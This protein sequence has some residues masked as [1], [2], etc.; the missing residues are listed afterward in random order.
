MISTGIEI[1]RRR[2]NSHIDS[3]SS[4][5]RQVNIKLHGHPETAYQ[6]FFAHDSITA[7]LE[8]QGFKVKRHAYGLETSFEA[9]IGSGGRLIV[10]CA[11]DDALPNIGHACGH[12]LIATSSIGAFLGAAT[13]LR[14]SGFAGRIRLLGTPAEEGGG[15]KVKLID[16]GAFKDDVAAAIMVHP[17]SQ[18][19]ISSDER[20]SG[21]AGIRSNASYKLRI[22]YKGKPA[23]AAGDPWNG[24]NALDAAVAAYNN[25]ALLRQQIQD[26]ERVHGVI[27]VG[28]TVPNVITEYT[29]MNWYVRCPTTERGV[30]LLDR[31][32]AC[33]E[34]AAITTGC[35]LT[36][37]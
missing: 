31:V 37:N 13:A 16:A 4:A 30:K 14:E 33:F 23:H 27:E 10:Y 5:L 26:Y 25:V 6:E 1:A 18:Q 32:K 20:F 11:E 8:E 36:Y 28:G 35:T 7:F 22:E 3:K 15:G 21:C 2:I 34:A 9:E 12:N 29:R 24:I 17:A 19:Q